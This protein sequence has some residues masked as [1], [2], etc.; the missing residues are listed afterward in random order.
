MYIKEEVGKRDAAIQ[1][2]LAVRP[3]Y[4]HLTDIE[5]SALGFALDQVSEDKRFE[6]DVCRMPDREL[7]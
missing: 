6:I 2:Q 7:L 4:W 5:K 1:K 3:V